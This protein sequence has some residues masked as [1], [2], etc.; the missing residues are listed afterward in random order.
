MT[1]YKQKRAIFGKRRSQ[2]RMSIKGQNSIASGKQEDYGRQAEPKEKQDL[3]RPA[4]KKMDGVGDGGTQ[5]PNSYP[6]YGQDIKGEE[7]YQH[8]NGDGESTLPI[9]G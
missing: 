4:P 1:P 6:D 2:L 5:C 3:S 9:P 7:E 8:V